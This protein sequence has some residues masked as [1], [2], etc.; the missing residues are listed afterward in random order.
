MV[1]TINGI[2]DLYCINFFNSAKQIKPKIKNNIIKTC[3]LKSEKT[4][5]ETYKSPEKDLTRISFMCRYLF[6][7]LKKTLGLIS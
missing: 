6:F 5:N 3:L 4:N 1:K 7:Y 2:T